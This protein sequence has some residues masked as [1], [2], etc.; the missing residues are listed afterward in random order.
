MKVSIYLVWEKKLQH[1]T[2]VESW[3]LVSLLFEI[4]LDNLPEMF[5]DGN[6]AL[7][8]HRDYQLQPLQHSLVS[9]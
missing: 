8:S 7:S 3:T 1:I 4:V 9:H 6:L 5:P 2:V